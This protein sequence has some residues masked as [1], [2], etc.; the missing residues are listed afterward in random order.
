MTISVIVLNLVRSVSIVSIDCLMKSTPFHYRST[1]NSTNTRIPVAFTAGVSNVMDRLFATK[2][3]RAT[4][5][6]CALTG[7][8]SAMGSSSVSMDL[9]RKNCEK[10][11]FNECNDEEYR[12][13]NGMCI[14]EEFWLDGKT[15]RSLAI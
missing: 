10:L 4:T 3:S 8:T 9:T 14:A 7:T 11:E 15:Y 1:L 13:L 12:C 5:D 6:C 2:P